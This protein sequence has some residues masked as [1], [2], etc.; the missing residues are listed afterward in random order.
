MSF[1]CLSLVLSRSFKICVK[2]Y[3]VLTQVCSTGMCLGK[4]SCLLASIRHTDNIHPYCTLIQYMHPLVHLEH[5]LKSLPLL[6][7]YYAVERW[8]SRF[9][10]FDVPRSIH[11][12]QLPYVLSDSSVSPAPLQLPHDA[13]KRDNPSYMG[14]V[15]TQVN[16]K[17][18]TAFLCIVVVCVL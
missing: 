7:A 6:P 2:C 12:R 15:M 1:M 18:L 4:I 14:Q 3:I 5:F 10:T 13:D 8:F 9:C 11:N 16:I 17:Q